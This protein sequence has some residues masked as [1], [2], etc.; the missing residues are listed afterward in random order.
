[1]TSPDKPKVALTDRTEHYD[2]AVLEA[3]GLP[4]IDLPSA[5]PVPDAPPT[6]QDADEFLEAYY[7]HQE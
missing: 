2:D 5:A 1:M 4:P 6:S 3:G 7:R